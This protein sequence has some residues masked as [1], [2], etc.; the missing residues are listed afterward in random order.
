MLITGFLTVCSTALLNLLLCGVFRVAVRTQ[1]L[2]VNIMLT[3]LGLH[4][5]VKD[6]RQSVSSS[7]K[8][9]T[10]SRT[11]TTSIQVNQLLHF[12]WK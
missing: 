12:L 7:V 9:G 11:K 1:S 8:M 4:A 10:S 3:D 6:E 2:P 5:A